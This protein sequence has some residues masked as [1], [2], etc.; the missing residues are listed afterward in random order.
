MLGDAIQVTRV[1]DRQRLAPFEREDNPLLEDLAQLFPALLQLL[2]FAPHS[3]GD[4][5]AAEVP[6]VLGDLIRRVL[7]RPGDGGR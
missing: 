4:R 6:A 1:D 5:D 2:R 3:R 7:H